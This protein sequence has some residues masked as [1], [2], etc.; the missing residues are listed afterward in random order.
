MHKIN[1]EIEGLAELQARFKDPALTGEPIAQAIAEIAD[2]ARKEAEKAID[3]GQ[4]MAVRTITANVQKDNALIFSMLPAKRAMSIEEGRKPG[5]D[6]KIILAQAIRWKDA[7]GHP[8]SG[9]EVAAEL[10]SRGS[11]GKAYIKRAE[12]E[13][14]KA[15]PDAVRKAAAQVEA[16]WRAGR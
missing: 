8:A 5:D 11:Q 16:K 2:A 14:K 4:G 9:Y 12:E 15:A 13:A 7:V 10:S 1:V 6:A 3:G